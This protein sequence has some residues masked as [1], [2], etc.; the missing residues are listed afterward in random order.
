MLPL[1]RIEGVPSKEE[2]I[3]GMAYYAGS[4]PASA[5]CKGCKWY[6]YYRESKEGKSYRT[7]ACNMFKKL[8]G[9][10]GP[11]LKAHTPACKYFERKVAI[12]G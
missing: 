2:I 12:N 4:G 3:P 9:K 5:T 8:T 11:R 7:M 6:G 1:T 10:F